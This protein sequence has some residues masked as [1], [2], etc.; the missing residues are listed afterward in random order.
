MPLVQGGRLKAIAVTTGSRTQV[1]PDLPTVAEAGYPR[2]QSIARQ[3]IVAPAGTPRPII[4][5]LSREL[6]RILKRRRT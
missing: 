4:D 5:R 6:S 1:L 3:G 2:F